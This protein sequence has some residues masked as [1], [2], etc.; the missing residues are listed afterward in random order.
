MELYCRYTNVLGEQAN[1]NLYLLAL[2][3]RE[4]FTRSRTSPSLLYPDWRKSTVIY[5][6]QFADVA[7]RLEQEIRLRLP[8]VITGLKDSS[9][10]HWIVRNPA[11]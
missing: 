3:K 5:D 6:N 8:E 11:Y 2:S 1:R 9:I 7:A 4:H 10:R